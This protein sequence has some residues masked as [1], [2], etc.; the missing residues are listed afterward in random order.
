M[1]LRSAG[2]DSSSL[3]LAEMLLK[4]DLGGL[5]CYSMAPDDPN[6]QR[7]G[8]EPNSKRLGLWA[9]VSSATSKITCAFFYEGC[10][11]EMFQKLE[12]LGVSAYAH[13]PVGLPLSAEPVNPKRYEGSDTSISAL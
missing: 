7:I 4:K 10:D 12:S 1:F 13:I 5:R 2:M 9:R 6:W 8:F 11:D 3:Q